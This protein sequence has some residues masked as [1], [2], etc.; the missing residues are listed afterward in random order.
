[1][2]DS[3]SKGC[4]F[5]SQQK[6]Q[7]NFLLQSQLCVLTLIQCQFHP[8]VTA[9]ACKRPQSFCLKCKWQVTPKHAYILDPLKSEWAD[10]AAVQAECGNISGNK[11]AE[12]LRTDPV[13]KS[14]ISLCELIS[15]P[16]KTTKNTGGEWIVKH[17]SKILA[18]MEK[19]TKNR[20][21]N[22]Q[23]FVRV[24]KGDWNQTDRSTNYLFRHHASMESVII[25]PIRV[26][27]S[28]VQCVLGNVASSY[29]LMEHHAVAQ[30]S[31]MGCG[32]IGWASG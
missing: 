2:A 19:V 8:R 12:P 29:T 30:N 10:Y 1:M 3:W 17:S 7:E 21:C 23:W 16:K 31:Y 11:L 26:P 6:R 14:G 24:E 4:E 27:D 15:I 18:C 28:D 20:S 25:F 13:L 9:V 5:E 22:A 32:L